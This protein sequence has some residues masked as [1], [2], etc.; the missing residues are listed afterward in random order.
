MTKH[1]EVEK[2]EGGGKKKEGEEEEKEGKKEE[3]QGEEQGERRGG[4]DGGCS[5]S[6]VRRN[7]RSCLD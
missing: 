1:L 5:L 3:Q 6:S 2:K 7:F 4:V